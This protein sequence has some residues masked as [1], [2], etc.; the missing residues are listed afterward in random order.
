MPLC[1]AHILQC[2]AANV[3]D[4][5]LLAVAFEAM[6]VWLI[7]GALFP[8]T[9]PFLIHSMFSSQASALSTVLW[10]FSTHNIWSEAGQVSTPQSVLPLWIHHYPGLFIC[11]AYYLFTGTYTLEV[12]DFPLLPTSSQVG[13]RNV[14]WMNKWVFILF[15]KIHI[16]ILS[17]LIEL[18]EFS[19]SSLSFP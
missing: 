12:R 15:L 2:P 14:C 3:T 1:N 19:I 5:W 11:C 16:E 18:K 6:R 13:I 4:L 10:V 17:P 8:R 9:H 7:S